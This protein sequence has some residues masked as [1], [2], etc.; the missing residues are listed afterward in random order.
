[1]SIFLDALFPAR[2]RAAFI[3]QYRFPA[4]LERRLAREHPEWGH[5]PRERV[6]EGL[7]QFFLACHEA[8]RRCRVGPLGMPSPSAK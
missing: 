8:Q 2:R 7:R 6:L 3:R 4:E 1:M 5:G